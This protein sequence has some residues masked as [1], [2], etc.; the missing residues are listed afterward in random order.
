[1]ARFIIAGIGLLMFVGFST[2]F[3][4]KI[5]PRIIDGY[6]AKLGQFP[7]YA[8]L[9]IK[10]FGFGKYFVQNVFSNFLIYHFKS[11]NFRSI[12]VWSL[13]DHRRMAHYISA[14]H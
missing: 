5:S 7:Y 13:T 11:F 8:Y 4:Y 9:D 3:A 6:P 12:I 1:M 14:L 10:T 2:T